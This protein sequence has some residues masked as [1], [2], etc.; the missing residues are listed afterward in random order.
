MEKK[1]SWVH[2]TPFMGLSICTLVHSYIIYDNLIAKTSEDHLSGPTS[3]LSFRIT[4]SEA[5]DLYE[6]GNLTR[7]IFDKIIQLRVIPFFLLLFKSSGRLSQVLKCYSKKT[8]QGLSLQ[9]YVYDTTSQLFQLAF[10][11]YHG[12][13]YMLYGDCYLFTYINMII[14]LQMYWYKGIHWKQAFF[15]ISATFVLYQIT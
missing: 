14:V 11:K 8:T 1:K 9:G 3:K 6:S 7:D 4:P 2:Y 5:W 10:Y 12:L 13:H 15:M